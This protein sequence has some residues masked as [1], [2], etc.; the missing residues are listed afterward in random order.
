MPKT[1][2]LV[3]APFGYA[4]LIR[5]LSAGQAVQ[6]QIAGRVCLAS[7]GVVTVYNGLPTAPEGG[8]SSAALTGVPIVSS[9]YD[10][11]GKPRAITG[12]SGV[13]TITGTT[14]VVIW[15]AVNASG[16]E[17]LPPVDPPP[18][19]NYGAG[20]WNLLTPSEADSGQWSMT[21]T[22]NGGPSLSMETVGTGGEVYSAAT[23][24]ASSGLGLGNDVG[25]QAILN[26]SGVS[27]YDGG[28][29]QAAELT[30]QQLSLRNDQALITCSFAGSELTL[31]NPDTEINAILNGPLGLR[32]TGGG[33]GNPV[34]YRC[35]GLVASG[36]GSGVEFKFAGIRVVSGVAYALL[37]IDGDEFSVKIGRAHV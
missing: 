18:Q 33:A 1:E 27:I 15:G 21:A 8:D 11:F 20:A 7:T 3:T 26:T 10:P 31:L 5:D 19:Y 34:A 24:D 36:S 17:Y 29:G 4:P 22:T 28:T 13:V 12:V 16:N 32:F 14:W 37:K 23:L 2:I 35:D 9:W 6:V 25:N 30:T